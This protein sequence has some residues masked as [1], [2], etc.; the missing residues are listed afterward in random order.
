[1]RFVASDAGGGSIVEA[2]VDDIQILLTGVTDTP[3]AQVGAAVFR[4][5]GARPNPTRSGATIDFSLEKAGTARLAIYDVQGRLVRRL[6]DGARAA[7]PQSILW[8]GRDE[9]GD[10]AASGIYLLRLQGNGREQ[11]RKIV[12]LE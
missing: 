8:D 1:V 7:G 10:P 2:G 11:V 12:R 4:L 6:V 3:D 9:K 5:S